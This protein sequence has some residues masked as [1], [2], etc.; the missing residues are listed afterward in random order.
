MAQTW[1]AIVIGAGI[2]GASVARELATKGFKTLSIDKLPAASY[3]STSNSCAI[4]RPY[5]STVHGSGVAYESHFYWSDW[6]NFCGVTDEL[7]MATYNNCGCLVIKT[8]HNDFLEGILKVMDEIGCP[9]EELSPE[10]V[11]ERVPPICTDSFDHPRRTD[12]PQFG[13][14][15]GRS[16]RGAVLFPRGGYISDPQLAGHNVQR[17][18]EAKG[19]TFHFNTSVVAIRRDGDRV[20]GVTLDNSEEIDAPVVVNVA[21]PHSSKINEMAGI[22]GTTRITTRALRHE[23]A[24]VPSPEGYDVEKD[25]YVFSDSEIGAYTRPETGNH[26]L[27][28]SED[29]ACDQKEWV[30]PDEY[31]TEFTHMWTTLVMR[32]AQRFPDLKIPNSARGAIDLYDVTEDWGPIYDKSDLKGFY[33]A[34]GTSGNQFKNAPI[35]GEMMADLIE[36]CENGRDHDADPVHFRLK[37]IDLDV[38][39]GF[40]SR[41]RE[42]NEN[43]SFSVLG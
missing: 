14:P 39:L 18:A 16:V 7:G 36:A 35:A 31:L 37:N 43:S 6:E 11:K 33:L 24:H 3:G 32:Q 21:G 22:A 29:P 17:A 9:Y 19:A 1:D 34:I 15:Q 2:I 10:Q 23:V 12:D 13:E 26:I 41:N 30:D 8:E 4:I 38:D 40:F 28:G 25:G 42:I 27:I 20:I 5:Y